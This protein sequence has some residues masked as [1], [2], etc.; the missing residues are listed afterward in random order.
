MRYK[1]FT[2]SEKAWHAMFEAIES[3]QESVYLEMYIFT[4][5]MDK[6]NFL[7]LL[8]Q[9]AQS[10]LRVRIILD[11]L[12]SAGLSNKAI[13]V[14]RQAGAELF[15]LSHFLHRTHRKILVVDENTAFVGGVNFHQSSWHWNDLAVQVKGRLV[16]YIIQSFANVYAECGGKDIKIL[17]QNKK[18]ISDKTRTWLVEHFP[19]SKKSSLKKIYK[20]HI[21]KAEKNIILITP[22][23]TPKR[24]LV[25]I[26][27]QAVLRGV[28]VEVL[29]PKS[30]DHFIIDRVNYFYMFKLSKL[31]VDF[32]IQ[33]QMNHAK[34]MIIDF[35][36]GIV[37]SN[38]LD[39]LSFEL[40]SE[41][42]IFLKDL[43]A[44]RSL[45]KIAEEWKRGAVLFDFKNYKP[46]LLDYV[47]SPILRFFSYI[48]SKIL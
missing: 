30:T 46:K 27:H 48:L 41:V 22:Y 32:Y 23:F 4:D 34:V 37:G 13:L 35:K 36:E 43:N 39:F 33:P 14:L 45:L 12:G 31:G 10:G 47:L 20:E 16:K 8:E 38:N 9:K 42:G 26:L 15:F 25:G 7:K 24:W 40:N 17:A 28:K 3:A 21:G 6:F 1:F 44:V 2:N 18:I 29:L 11:S 5:D 19:V